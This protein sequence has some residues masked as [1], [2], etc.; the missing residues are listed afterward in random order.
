MARGR[1]VPIMS[2]L[3]V[4]V[5]G[6]LIGGVSAGA[7]AAPKGPNTF[8]VEVLLWR[9]AGVYDP[10]GK[11]RVFVLG[12]DG[13]ELVSGYTAD[14]GAIELVRPKSEQKPKYVLV[15]DSCCYISGLEWRQNEEHYRIVLTKRALP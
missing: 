8:L 10:L 9:D 6:L 4:V 3:T 11:V 13:T 7:E 2:I 12:A 14:Y 1:E 15:E 5:G